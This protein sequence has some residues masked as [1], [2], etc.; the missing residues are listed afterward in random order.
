[1]G[2]WWVKNEPEKPKETVVYDINNPKHVKE[3][4]IRKPTQVS[5]Q[6]MKWTSKFG[7]GKPIFPNRA[8]QP[9]PAAIPVEYTGQDLNNIK[10]GV[11]VPTS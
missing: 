2:A 1:M 5:E 8:N 7:D 4:G 3:F 11:P 10:F 6:N 9:I